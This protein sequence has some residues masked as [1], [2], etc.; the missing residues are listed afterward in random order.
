MCKEMIPIVFIMAIIEKSEFLLITFA[1]LKKILSL[2]M[3][4]V[5]AGV[6]YL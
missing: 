3:S 5:R 1:A 6:L 4:I 2:I